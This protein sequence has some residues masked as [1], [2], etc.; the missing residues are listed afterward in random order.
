MGTLLHVPVIHESPD[1]GVVA[2]LVDRRGAELAG[3]E[4]WERHKRTVAGFWDA[5]EGFFRA[6]DPHGMKIFQDSLAADGSLA[7]LILEEGAARGSRNHRIVLDLLDRGAVAVK[8][9]DIGMLK[10][11]YERAL[12]LAGDASPGTGVLAMIAW[13]PKPDDLLKRRDRHIARI[14]EENLGREG[15]GILF[16]GA[17][18]DVLAELSSEVAV[19]RVKDRDMMLAYQKTLMGQGP[20]DVHEELG[21]YLAEP[22][23]PGLDGLPARQG[24]N[25]AQEGQP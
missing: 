11:E 5:M 20:G 16:I 2:S 3:R 23:F 21:R 24:A 8:T 6:L 22:V 19:L 18:H 12:K 15:R 7:R 25:L 1:L 17:F 9:E 4:R 10:E 14:V 13:P